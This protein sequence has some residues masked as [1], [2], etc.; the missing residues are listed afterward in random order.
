MADTLISPAIAA[1]SAGISKSSLRNHTTNPAYA[2]LFSEYA[3]R[4]PRLFTVDDVRLLRFIGQQTAQGQTH[5][6]IAAAVRSGAL[7]G[8][9]WQPPEQPMPQGP[10][11]APRPAQDQPAALV[12]ATAQ[13]LQAELVHELLDNVKALAGAEARILALEEEVDHLRGLLDD[14]AELERLRAR[15][16]EEQPPA[17]TRPRWAFWRRR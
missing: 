1:R 9:D 8:F 16:A 4:T 15:L 3:R 11:E 13:A 6:G 14:K 10:Q 5:E 17:V 2:A 7:D 12:L